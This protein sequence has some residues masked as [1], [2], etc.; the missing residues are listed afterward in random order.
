MGRRLSPQRPHGTPTRWYWL[1]YR[2]PGERRPRRVPCDP[3]TEDE[4]EAWDQLNVRLGEK[5]AVRVEREA[6]EQ[7]SVND[8]LDLVVL[9]YEDQGQTLQ[10]ARTIAWRAAL[11][12]ARARDVRR[13]HLDQIARTWRKVGV[14][15]PAG[16]RVLAD[17]RSFKWE[18]RPAVRIRPID[19]ATMNRYIATLRRAYKLGKEKLQLVTPLTFPHFTETNRGQYM[20]ED[21]CHLVVDWL[22]VNEGEMIADLTRLAYLTGIRQGQWV[23][24]QKRHVLITGSGAKA[25]WKLEWPAHEHKAGKK[26]GKPHSVALSGEPLEIIQRV[27]ARRL[28][29]LADLFHRDRASISGDEVRR[30]FK[31]ACEANDIPYG[32]GNG[33]IF[34]DTRH[35]AVTNLVAA[36]TG[37]AVAMSITGHVTQ[38]VFTRY[39]ITRD[40]VQEAAFTRQGDHL[41]DQRGTTALPAQLAVRDEKR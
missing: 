9:D 15:W 7:I 29:D 20:T 34:H 24:L 31:R 27:W 12:H 28:P 5:I 39:N 8:L 32:R 11:G 36:G 18:A 1:Q 16:E 35:S 17:G 3:R 40:E 19:V 21:Q 10:P 23:A 41:A 38:S 37:E 25:R 22:A 13:D 30:A 4:A 6:I 2:L 26:T 33:V 14:S